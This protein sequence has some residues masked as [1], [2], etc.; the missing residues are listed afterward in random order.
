MSVFRGLLILALFAGLPASQ[1]AEDAAVLIITD[2]SGGEVRTFTRAELAALPQTRFS[3]R[4][5]FTDGRPEFAGPLARDVLA[6]AGV[7]D[8]R[9]IVF[10]AVNDYWVDV[11][12]EELRRYDVIMALRMNGRDLSLRDKGPIWL[13]YPLDRHAELSDPVYSGR[14]IWQMDRASAR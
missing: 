4:T 2:S 10:T 5:S 14:L 3:T 6:A 12:F 1:A 9:S 7:G 13:M 8:A 11:P